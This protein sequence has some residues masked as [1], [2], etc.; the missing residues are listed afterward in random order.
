MLLLPTQRG[1][2]IGF[3]GLLK[4]FDG[5]FQGLSKNSVWKCD[6]TFSSPSGFGPVARANQTQ[7]YNT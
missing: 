4:I 5:F 6:L 1:S 2:K 7:E 3:G